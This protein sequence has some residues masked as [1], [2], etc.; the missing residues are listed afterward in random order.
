MGGW[1]DVI[2][3]SFAQA[4]ERVIRE[5]GAAFAFC[6]YTDEAAS[7]ADDSFS[8]ASLYVL[9]YCREH[10]A[11][12]EAHPECWLHYIGGRYGIAT[13]PRERYRPEQAPREAKQATYRLLPELSEDLLRGELR[14]V[15]RVLQLLADAR[16]REGLTSG[17]N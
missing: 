16:E 15:H 7:R 3:L 14:A 1:N 9:T 12:S 13:P 2:S 17:A 5:K 4:I 8:G 11:R 10:A 6:P